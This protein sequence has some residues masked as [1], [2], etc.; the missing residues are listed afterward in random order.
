MQK[1]RQFSRQRSQQDETQ[2][3]PQCA[4]DLRLWY[5]LCFHWQVLVPSQ[6][7]DFLPSIVQYAM[8]LI[9]FLHQL[10][11]ESFEVHQ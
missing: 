1:A 9:Q 6:R 5:T 7:L 4:E 11:C 2:T 8:L 10:A 3:K